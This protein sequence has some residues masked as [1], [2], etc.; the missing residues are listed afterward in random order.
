VAIQTQFRSTIETPAVCVDRALME[1]NIRRMAVQLKGRRIAFRPHVK[2]HKSV[3]IAERQIAAGAVGLTTATLGEAEVFAG[4]GFEDIFIAYPLWFTDAKAARLRALLERA[5]VAVGVSSVAGAEQL[6]SKL[7]H[8]VPVDVLIEVD[9][10]EN[11][12]GVTDPHTAVRVAQAAERAGLRAIG[13]FTHVGHSYA[14][15]DAVAEAAADEVRTLSDTVEALR[16]AG[17]PV[18]VVSAGS[19][20]TALL[21]AEGAVTEERPGTFVFGD[22]QQVA[23]DAHPPEA[24]ALFIAATVVSAAHNHFVLDAGAKVLSKDAPKT[25][26]GYGTLPAYPG[27]RIQRLYDHHAVVTCSG[28][29]TPSLGE[30]VSVIPN[31]VCPVVN[32]TDEI[33]ILGETGDEE[34][35]WSVDARGR[36]T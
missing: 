23:L 11:R 6:G 35:R 15:A 13:V 2:S 33:V 5:R 28:G 12:T 26:D 16:N 20:P 30:R 29:E 4:A 19:T 31:H 10:G 3:V 21:S 36:N 22:R 25:L 27:A 1:A 18:E 9:S 34:D 17:H 24:V 8:G 7:G 14:G 32:L